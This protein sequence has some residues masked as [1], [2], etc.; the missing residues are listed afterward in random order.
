MALSSA[1]HGGHATFQV[2]NPHRD[3][4]VSLDRLVD[5]VESAGYP[6]RRIQDHA[7]WFAAF[8][9]SLQALPAAQR[10]DSS[11]PILHL[12]ATPS[13]GGD[14]DRIDTTRFRQQV[15]RRRPAGE[16]AIPHLGEAYLHKVLADLGALGV[17]PPPAARVQPPSPPAGSSPAERSG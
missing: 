8:G 6:L 11:L 2:S 10:Q 15:R 12:W 13:R 14:A 4:G 3:D 16:A 17:V 1:F 5:W 9:A 7:A